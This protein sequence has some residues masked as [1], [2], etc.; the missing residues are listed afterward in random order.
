M[1]R[2]NCIPV[3]VP[4]VT[5]TKFYQGFCKGVLWPLF[6]MVCVDN[7]NGLVHAER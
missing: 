2:F 7:K 6:H 5:L 3:F 1:D 4:K